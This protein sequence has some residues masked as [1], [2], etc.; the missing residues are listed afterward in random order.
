[1]Q[2]ITGSKKFPQ[3]QKSDLLT[4]TGKQ[5]VK[6]RRRKPSVWTRRVNRTSKAPTIDRLLETVVMVPTSYHHHIPAYTFKCIFVSF[7]Y[8]CVFLFNILFL[9]ETVVMVPTS[10]HHQLP[11]FK[12]LQMNISGAIVI[13]LFLRQSWD[14]LKI[15]WDPSQIHDRLNRNRVH[16]AHQPQLPYMF[17]I[18]TDSFK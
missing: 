3:T 16:G 15:L 17:C 18:P 9:L 6:D 13:H 1:M 10:Y 11:T 12:C 8:I 5:F 2:I 4:L 14:G 7:F